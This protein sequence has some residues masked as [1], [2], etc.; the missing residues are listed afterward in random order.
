M[1]KIILIGFAGSGKSAVG[2]ILANKLNCAF[3][4]TDC[5]V[6]KR[7]NL[8]VAEIFERCGEA[9]FRQLESQLLTTLVDA[10]GVVACGGGSVL[11]DSFNAFASSGVVVWLTAT[12]QTVYERLGNSPRPLFDKL[13]VK[14]L[15]DYMLRRVPFYEKYARVKFSTDGKTPEQVAEQIYIHLTNQ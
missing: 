11:V 1:K 10:D 6:A 3:V 13:S 2:K 7:S 14:E 4:D 8:T 5:E 15:E 12:A 9:R